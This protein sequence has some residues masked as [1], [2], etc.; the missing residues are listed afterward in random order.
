MPGEDSFPLGMWTCVN[1]LV[2][3]SH[4][5]LWNW[6]SP[7]FGGSKW[8]DPMDVGWGGRSTISGHPKMVLVYPTW[9]P[10]Y[11]VY[12]SI[13]MISLMCIF[14][15]W[16]IV[17][18]HHIPIISPVY[19]IHVFIPH[20]KR[21]DSWL[22]VSNIPITCYIYIYIICI[23][24]DISRSISIICYTSYIHIISHYILYILYIYIPLYIYI[25]ILIISPMISPLY[26]HPQDGRHLASPEIGELRRE[27][28]RGQNFC[29]RAMLMAWVGQ[30]L[31]GGDWNQQ[32][33]GI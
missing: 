20:C 27:R 7:N 19:V 24:C 29:A 22:I 6:D 33:I 12:G 8:D 21:S 30:K 1:L 31:V 15:L 5:F 3:F 18:I 26:P 2:R 28:F 25:Y 11:V 9:I 32:Q 16:Y 13:S 4:G 17:C 10:L 23:W 14:M